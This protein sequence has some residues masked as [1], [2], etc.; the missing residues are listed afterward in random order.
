MYLF[1]LEKKE[2]LYEIK[3]ILLIMF[4]S[5]AGLSTLVSWTIY[6]LYILLT[7]YQGISSSWIE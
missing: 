2:N 7:A 5:C 6:D 4:C 1:L 3:K